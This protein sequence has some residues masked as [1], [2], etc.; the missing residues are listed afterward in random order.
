MTSYKALQSFGKYKEGDI[1]ATDAK[2]YAYLIRGKGSGFRSVVFKL[3]NNS[4]VQK[5]VQ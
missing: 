4:K 1:F 5:V 2:F 3:D